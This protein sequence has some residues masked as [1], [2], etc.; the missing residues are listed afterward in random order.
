ME[1]WLKQRREVTLNMRFGT[2]S[3]SPN[4]DLEF[5]TN[6]LS[7]SE[8]DLSKCHSNTEQHT[9]ENNLKSLYNMQLLNKSTLSP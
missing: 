6:S 9:I 3:L 4:G 2:L 1:Q 8:L 5:K 7:N